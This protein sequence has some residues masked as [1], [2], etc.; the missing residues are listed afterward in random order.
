MTLSRE[1]EDQD[2]N[3][4][5]QSYSSLFGAPYLKREQSAFKVKVNLNRTS[6]DKTAA[7]YER[8]IHV[9]EQA[10]RS[11]SQTTN[12]PSRYEIGK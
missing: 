8:N 6:H 1:F 2:G 9:E 7:G 10:Q 5:H 4:I 12:Y 11:K 3:T